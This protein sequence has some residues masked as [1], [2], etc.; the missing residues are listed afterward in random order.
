MQALTV[1]C[2]YVT[3]F[4]ERVIIVVGLTVVGTR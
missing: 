3:V 2:V 1:M 4:T